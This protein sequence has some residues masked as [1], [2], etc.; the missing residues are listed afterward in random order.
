MYQVQQVEVEGNVK[1]AVAEMPENVF[2]VDN[3]VVGQDPR[4]GLEISR[5]GETVTLAVSEMEE[6]IKK[7]R[8]R[9]WDD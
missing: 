8:Q 7:A 4:G 2:L 5:D 3:I 9:G 6:I 1:T